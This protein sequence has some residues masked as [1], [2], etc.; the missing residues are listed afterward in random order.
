MGVAFHAY[1]R[2]G[3]YLIE[4]SEFRGF[5]PVEIAM[6]AAIVRHHRRGFPRAAYPPYEALGARNRLRVARM[7]ALLH[8]ADALDRSLDQSVETVSATADQAHVIL[9]LA[10]SNVA[11]R[12]DWA[13]RAQEAVRATFDLDLLFPPGSIVDL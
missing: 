1:H 2:H 6:L 10:G 4:H 13:K 7:V 8:V 12:P 3:A 11:I 5:D 9:E